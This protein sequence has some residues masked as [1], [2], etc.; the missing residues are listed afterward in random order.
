MDITLIDNNMFKSVS[1]DMKFV[2]VHFDKPYR[3]IRP[4][5]LKSSIPKKV[6]L[7]PSIIR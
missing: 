4:A 5:N 6:E 3:Y 7:A 1:V 2:G